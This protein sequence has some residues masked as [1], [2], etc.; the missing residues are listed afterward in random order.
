MKQ[1]HTLYGFLLILLF[2]SPLAATE[3]WS[4]PVN[5]ARVNSL[6][7]DAQPSIS[8]DQLTL[9]FMSNRP[10]GVGSQDIW[11]SQRASTNDL[12]GI[13][14]N[15]GSTVN[16]VHTEGGPMISADGTELYFY[17]DR[18]GGC[19]NRDIW[20]ATRS[21]PTDAFSWNP[22]TNPGCK[23]NSAFVDS[24]P[25]FF[26]DPATGLSSLY[27]GS[28]R[29][30]GRNAYDNFDIYTSI[31]DKGEFGAPVRNLK[32]ISNSHD[33]GVSLSSDGLEMFYH[34][35]RPD[36]TNQD[37]WYSTRETLSD[38]WSIPLNIGGGV[39]T[40]YTEHAPD[41][42]RDGNVL[43]FD[44]NRPGTRGLRD[45][46]TSTRCFRSVNDNG[47][48]SANNLYTWNMQN[49]GDFLFATTFN[50][51]DGGEIW[52]Y[53]GCDW[54]RVMNGGFGDANNQGVRTLVAFN[55]Y[56]YAGTLDE[57]DGAE[58]WRS[59]DG[60]TWT[61]VIDDGFGDLANIS[62]RGMI[63]F[64]NYLYI[65]LQSQDGDGAEI[66]RSPDGEN[67]QQIVF[68]GLGNPDNDS[69][70]DFALFQQQLYAG[71]RSVSRGFTL[72]R[73]DDGINFDYVV[74]GDSD[75]P[76]GL[77]SETS[78]TPY[79]LHVGPAPA[80]TAGF[81]AR[82]LFVGAGNWATGASVFKTPDGIDF[83]AVTADGFGDTNNK[84]AWRFHNHDGD[85]WLGLSNND[86]VNDGGNLW[87]TSNGTDW[88]QMVGKD[89]I[90]GSPGFGNL[91]NWGIRSFATYNNRLYIGTAQCWSE[92]CLP[93]NT[94]TQ[95][96]EWRGDMCNI[97]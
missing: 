57:V 51:V 73:S 67:W 3:G 5:L 20:V 14:R 25:F 4:P 90:Y 1:Q 50:P 9:Y 87:R 93:L 16:S 33:S 40:P 84:F 62:V 36:G 37:I 97:D 26:A 86:I 78:R 34:S 81:N 19:G 70:H 79:H 66:W 54:T 63:Q 46:Y 68:Q 95:V 94:G 91:T 45:I 13:P 12:W 58:V 88:E 77:N 69:V 27:L 49:F 71:M 28:T 35:E 60:I 80:E 76:A 38:E 11:V 43:Y 22:P 39:N 52:R 53:D 17:S 89:G 2:I 8:S 82:E 32:I 7:M 65:G 30:Y 96:W 44:S 15:L 59:L 23:L 55:G 61:P 92:S 72:I 18:P 29:A 75:I 6:H 83:T 85:L 74:G 64:Q 10:G 56:L 41:L 42:T 48:G 24:G 31:R 21:D 47:F